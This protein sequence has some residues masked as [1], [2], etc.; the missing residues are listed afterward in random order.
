MVLRSGT[1][2]TLTQLYFNIY[3][4]RIFARS[5]SVSQFINNDWNKLAFTSDIPTSLKNPNKLTLKDSSF[6]E[7]EI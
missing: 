2:D 5:G 1:N 4:N 7:E 6:V 3:N